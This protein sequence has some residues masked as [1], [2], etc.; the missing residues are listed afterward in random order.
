MNEQERDELMARVSKALEVPEPSPLFWDHFP[1][2]VRAAVQTAP[3]DMRAGWWR[4]RAVVLALSVTA[5]AALASWAVVR[6]G[7]NVAG[8]TGPPSPA[9]N[10][11]LY[12]TQPLESDAEWAVVSSVAASAGVDALR[13]AGFGVTPG[14][15]DAAIEDLTQA[16]RRELM[17]LLEAE[18]KGDDPGGL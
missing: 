18:M 17:A 10:V 8:V 11:A 3:A 7:S 5:V 4:R 1:G 14:G 16:E 12:E 13:D 9:G 15:A 6:D 2:R